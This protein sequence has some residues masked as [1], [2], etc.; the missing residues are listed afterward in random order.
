L[1]QSASSFWAF[2]LLRGCIWGSFFYLLDS[3]FIVISWEIAIFPMLATG[4]CSV[5]TSISAARNKDKA[6]N[7]LLSACAS[8][9][10]TFTFSRFAPLSQQPAIAST[11]VSLIFIM[12]ALMQKAAVRFDNM[13]LPAKTAS[14]R[15]RF[16]VSMSYEIRTPL[17]GITDLSELCSQ[18]KL[19]SDAKYYFDQIDRSSKCYSR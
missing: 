4:T 12:L 15:E 11:M 2:K 1:A 8:S 7:Y 6:A 18:E 3:L 19:E 16:L 5:L 17:N 13:G 9:N 10:Q 14:A